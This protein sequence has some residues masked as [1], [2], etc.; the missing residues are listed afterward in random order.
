[1]GHR[2][3]PRFYEIYFMR[4]SFQALTAKHEQHPNASRN[5][6]R[7][8]FTAWIVESGIKSIEIFHALKQ[9]KS[10]ATLHRGIH[11]RQTAKVI[12]RPTDNKNKLMRI[13][14]CR[15]K[16]I[17]IGQDRLMKIG[18][19]SCRERVYISVV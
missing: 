10:G 8:H 6:E 3:R 7:G 4:D 13:S 12:E 1:M 11:F 18:R 19:A 5:K 16:V 9:I 2:S 15:N 17:G 14:L